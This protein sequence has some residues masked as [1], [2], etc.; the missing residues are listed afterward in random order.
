MLEYIIYASLFF[1]PLAIIIYLILQKEGLPKTYTFLVLLIALA[2][3]IF[4]PILHEKLGIIMA[5]LS[6]FLVIFYL[7]YLISL[8]IEKRVWD[9]LI[10]AE[11]SPKEVNYLMNRLTADFSREEL[12]KIKKQEQNF[13]TKQENISN[14]KDGKIT[15][16]DLINDDLKDEFT[17][18]HKDGF[19]LVANSNLLEDNKIESINLE[20]EEKYENCDIIIEHENS[21]ILDDKITTSTLVEESSEVI[22]NEIN[23]SEV[24]IILDDIVLE[25]LSK[26]IDVDEKINT[27]L[28]MEEKANLQ[29]NNENMIEAEI[30]AIDEEKDLEI[31]DDVIKIDMTEEALEEIIEPEPEPE[32]EPESEIEELSNEETQ[33]LINETLT[34]DLSIDESAD[35]EKEDSAT[36]HI[37]DLAFEKKMLGETNLALNYFQKAWEQANDGEL[38]YLLTI[39]LLELYKETGLYQNAIKLLEQYKNREN[40]LESALPEINKHLE[41]IIIL[42]TELKRLEFENIPLNKVPRWIRLLIDEKT[43]SQEA[44]I[45]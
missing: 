19:L 2:T 4:F 43:Q 10:Q 23:I 24:D 6:F 34:E 5:V 39:E 38:T 9:D 40:C 7:A 22:S 16:E 45:Q 31:N 25:I 14:E 30:D 42:D 32:P 26:E 35:K 3:I 33:V 27:E 15:D 17:N 18:N 44:N 28:D 8:S 1:L 13:E 36:M 41:F 12:K 11:L 37:I 29:E 20:Y 21:N